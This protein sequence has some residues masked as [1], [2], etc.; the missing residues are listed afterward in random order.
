LVAPHEAH[1]ICV[2]IEYMTHKKFTKRLDLLVLAENLDCRRRF[3]WNNGTP[4]TILLNILRTIE[5]LVR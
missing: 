4:H 2:D 3:Q 5:A 1:E